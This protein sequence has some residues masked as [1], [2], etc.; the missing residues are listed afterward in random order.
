MPVINCAR[1]GAARASLNKNDKA[2]SIESASAVPA[3]F[4]FYAY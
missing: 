3:G 2:K 4:V 1:V